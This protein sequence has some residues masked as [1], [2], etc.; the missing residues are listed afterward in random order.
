MTVTT[1]AS[2]TALPRPRVTPGGIPWRQTF[3]RGHLNGELQDISEVLVLKELREQG[4]K[5]TPL[6]FFFG[7][8]QYRLYQPV[9]VRPLD[10]RDRDLDRTYRAR[11]DAAQVFD[12]TALLQT[13]IANHDGRSILL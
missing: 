9:K 2:P 8:P 10:D 1:S 12:V 11:P 7:W 13:L 6:D 4:F 5:V 3:L